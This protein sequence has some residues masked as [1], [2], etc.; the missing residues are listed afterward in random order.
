MI[1]GG[2]S[3]DVARCHHHQM[4][5]GAAPSASFAF[6]A[7]GSTKHALPITSKKRNALTPLSIARVEEGV[8][9]GV[10]VSF[11]AR[12]RIKKTQSPAAP[13]HPKMKVNRF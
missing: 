12:L 7:M 11:L 13:N 10:S 2:R 6:M 5:L 8:P 4:A 3:T 9:P 1:A